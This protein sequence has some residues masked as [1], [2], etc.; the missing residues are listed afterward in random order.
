[1]EAALLVDLWW[2]SKCSETDL[3]RL[4]DEGL[5]ETKEII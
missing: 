5:L 2:K 1:M 4:V 3:L